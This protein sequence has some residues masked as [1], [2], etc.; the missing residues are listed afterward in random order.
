V[1]VTLARWLAVICVSGL[2]VNTWSAATAWAACPDCVPGRV[3]RATIG[4]DPAFWSY[5]LMT[6]L[7]FLIMATV[8]ALVHRGAR[9]APRINDNDH[10]HA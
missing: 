9:S 4:D 7:P 2:V 10:T 5:V 1:L 3:A 6:A 8:A